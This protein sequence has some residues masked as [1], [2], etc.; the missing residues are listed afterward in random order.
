MLCGCGCALVFVNLEACHH[1][2]HNGY[3]VVKSQFINFPSSLSEFNMSFAEVMFEIIPCFLHLVYALP[4]P[5]IVFEDSLPV[6]DD[7]GEVYCLNLSQLC[8]GLSCVFNQVVD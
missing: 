7:E 5:D 2:V 3:G 8:F 1:L 4:R 6:E